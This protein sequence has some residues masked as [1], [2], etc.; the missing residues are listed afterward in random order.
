[1]TNSFG[2]VGYRGPA[3]PEGSRL[4]WT[5][6]LSGLGLLLVAV[7]GW[8]GG[9]L[10]YSHGVGARRPLASADDSPRGGPE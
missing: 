1:G 2:K 8:L 9:D 6:V 10:V 4:A 3:P 7:G 5:L